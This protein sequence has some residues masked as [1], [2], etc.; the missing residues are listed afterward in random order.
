MT[1]VTFPPEIPHEVL[2]IA[3]A[4]L[5]LVLDGRQRP[6][7]HLAAIWADEAHCNQPG[8]KRSPTIKIGARVYCAHHALDGARARGAL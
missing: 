6:D 7:G 3:F 5:G 2:R 1:T 4:N 8:C